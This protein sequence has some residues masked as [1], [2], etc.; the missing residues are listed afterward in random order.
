M[1]FLRMTCPAC[2]ETI[3]MDD[4]LDTGFCMYCGAAFRVQDEIQRFQ[5]KDNWGY[6]VSRWK[7]RQQKYRDQVDPWV[8]AMCAIVIVIVAIMIIWI[9][10]AWAFK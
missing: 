1:A 7:Q 5:A 9:L 4:T 3:P 8:N 2:N 6:H 10:L